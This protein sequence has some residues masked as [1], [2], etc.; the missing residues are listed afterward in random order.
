MLYFYNFIAYVTVSKQI[1]NNEIIV[2]RIV[3]SVSAN[4][5]WSLIIPR[6]L[7]LNHI[8]TKIV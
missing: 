1:Y 2:L 5:V 3:L 4:H 6:R 8:N 7:Q